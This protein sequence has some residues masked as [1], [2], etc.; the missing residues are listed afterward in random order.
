VVLPE[1]TIVALPSP[2]ELLEDPPLPVVVLTVPPAPLSVVALELVLPPDPFV[3]A[4]PLVTPPDVLVGPTV[5]AA[6]AFVPEV[7]VVLTDEVSAAPSDEV[8]VLGL[9]APPSDDEA[10]A[11]TT[12]RVRL[13]ERARKTP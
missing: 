8:A 4:P 10:H 9:P 3:I 2:P 13:A 5:V 11:A 6:A 12:T 7:A 1:P